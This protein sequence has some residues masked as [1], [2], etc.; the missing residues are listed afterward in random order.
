M[1]LNQKKSLCL[2]IHFS[3][4]QHIPYY[5][6][7][8]VNELAR[9]FDEVVLLS[10]NKTL[11]TIPSLPNNVTIAFQENIGYDF[12]RFYN[13]YQSINKDDYYR[14]ACVNDSNILISNLDNILKWENIAPFDFWGLVDSRDKPWFST[15]SDDHHIQ[16]H[17]LIFHK[18]AIDFLDDYFK[19]VKIDELFSEKDPKI[20]RRNVIDKWEIGLSQFM[21]SKGLN[22]GHHIDSKAITKHFKIRFDSNISHILYQELLKAGYPLIKK[23]VVLDQKQGFGKGEPIWKKLIKKYGNRQWKLDILIEELDQMKNDYKL[24]K[25]SRLV[26]KIILHLQR[27]SIKPDEKSGKGNVNK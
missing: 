8:F 10:N 20:L 21:I 1:I 25:R 17:F 14:I 26:N 16:S 23:K 15:S 4:Q 22:I 11:K 2:F 13:Y 27:E 3:E 5:V 19:S 9:F 12:G 7:I 24:R 6:Q 18:N